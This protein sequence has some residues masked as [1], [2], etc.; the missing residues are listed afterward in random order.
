MT[1]CY[2]QEKRASRPQLASKL[3][4]SRHPLLVL[5]TQRV[6]PAATLATNQGFARKESPKDHSRMQKGPQRLSSNKAHV[7]HCTEASSLTVELG[8]KCRFERA[9]GISAFPQKADIVIALQ[10]AAG[11]S[12]SYPA[13]SQP[14][15]CLTSPTTPSA[16]AC[17]RP[18]QYHQMFAVIAPW[19]WQGPVSRNHPTMSFVFRRVSAQ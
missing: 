10:Q 7:L 5:V 8:Q 4:T 15:R 3:P 2:G 19:F 16:A 17:S 11:S 13:G 9:P 14:R 1:F 12:T 18:D 6:R